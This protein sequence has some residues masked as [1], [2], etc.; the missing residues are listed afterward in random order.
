M[1]Y[2]QAIW[3]IGRYQSAP[4]RLH[5][6]I[7]LLILIM[8]RTLGSA[9]GLIFV[10]VVHE[11]GHAVII[12]AVGGRI[13][14]IIIHGFGGYCRWSGT[15]STR[16]AAM[17]AWGGVWAQMLLA[18]TTF[19]VL[20]FSVQEIP[21][22]TFVFDFIQALTWSNLI[23][24]GINLLPVPPL[25]GAEAWP[26]LPMLW[27]DLKPQVLTPSRAA[28]TPNPRRTP[29]NPPRSQD[30]SSS[31]N[32]ITDPAESERLFK[33]IYDNMPAPHEDKQD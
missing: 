7:L 4:V 10:V 30:G 12:N 27:N 2:E 18:F 9:T 5:W 33:K 8:G 6:S 17:I 29:S 1:G 28:P 23:L 16:A 26:L 13:S 32:R 14:E 21:P 15:V 3:T 22:Q 24:I 20:A 31:S 25:D 19:V 11:L